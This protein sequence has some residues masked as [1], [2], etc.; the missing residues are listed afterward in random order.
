[1]KHPMVHL[2]IHLNDK[3][4]SLV[5][6]TTAGDQP[7][8]VAWQRRAIDSGWV[9]G[10]GIQNTSPLS[11]LIA[12][13]IRDKKLNVTA[14][15]LSLTLSGVRVRI[16]GFEATS[17]EELHDLVM[18]D[19]AHYHPFGIENTHTAYRVMASQNEE[20][21]VQRV[22]QVMTSYRA[23]DSCLMM[24]YA[25]G[26][27]NPILEAGVLPLLR[28]LGHGTIPEARDI[29][30]LC[31]FDT[32]AGMLCVLQ[33]GT[34]VFCQ[35]LPLGVQAL[36]TEDKAK[37][38]LR[39]RV[40]SVVEYAASLSSQALAMYTV[41]NSS[42][43]DLQAVSQCIAD[44][45]SKVKVCAVSSDQ[46]I[47]SFGIPQNSEGEE[48]PILALAAALSPSLADK[49]ADP[50]NLIPSR[51][52]ESIQT[53]R[54]MSRMGKII[55]AIVLLAVATIVP[56]HVKTQHVE[57]AI[58]VLESQVVTIRPTESKIQATDRQILLLER[59]IHVLQHGLKRMEVLPWPQLLVGIL[60]HV[61]A[62]LRLV[63]LNSHP[64]GSFVILGEALNEQVVHTYAE[65][66]EAV[67]FIENVEAEEVQ[68]DSENTH[69]VEYR[70]VGLLKREES[71]TP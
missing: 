31:V 61:P 57:A 5:A 55:M 14:V 42:Q 49:N 36:V 27:S 65:Q 37:E 15:Q 46:I 22:L 51:S 28:V 11:R 6:I 60:N 34:P 59:E 63:E 16:G 9:E 26:L 53:R 68:Y 45:V 29:A 1:M 70:I 35:N 24:C 18:Q 44:S 54:D 41:A 7:Q 58:T 43:E 13:F 47:Q 30:L 66:L 50:L 2:G 52:M 71:L 23:G 10:G 4:L 25:A 19:L 32:D 48:I 67:P 20:D 3:D 56:V 17:D 39:D 40:R 38:T 8:L 12:R 33:H 21:T 64:N 69:A 62:G